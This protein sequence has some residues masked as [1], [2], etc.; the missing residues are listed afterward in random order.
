MVIN[1]STYRFFFLKK[2]KRAVDPSRTR[3]LDSKIMSETNSTSI[4]NDF[5]YE[6]SVPKKEDPESIIKIKH[7]KIVKKQFE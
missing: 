2:S 1:K 4:P 7:K 6:N 5:F 3:S